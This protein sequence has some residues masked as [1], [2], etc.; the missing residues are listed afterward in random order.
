MVVVEMIAM[1]LGRVNNGNVITPDF[2][3]TVAPNSPLAKFEPAFEQLSNILSR[4]EPFLS[5]PPIL[6]PFTTPPMQ[7]TVPHSTDP[8][9]RSE[10][11][12][13]VNPQYSSA[14]SVSSKSNESVPEPTTDLFALDFLRASFSALKSTLLDLPLYRL[15]E[16][17]IKA[18]YSPASH[19]PC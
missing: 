2:E 3:F 18:V 4:N 5:S 9:H 10:H 11:W 7:I 19:S 17:R 12:S 15:S 14:S 16:Y 8:S 6:S 13:P 1:E